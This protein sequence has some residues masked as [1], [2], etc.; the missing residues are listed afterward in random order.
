[1][2]RAVLQSRAAAAPAVQQSIDISYPPGTQQQTRRTLL[3][4][5]NC[6]DRRRTPYVDLAA[7]YASSVDNGRHRARANRLFIANESVPKI[8]RNG[9]VKLFS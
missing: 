3:Q 9:A 1:V 2:L 4:Q 8:I 5:M 6:T 7:Y